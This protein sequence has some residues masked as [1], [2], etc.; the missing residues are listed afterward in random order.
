HLSVVGVWIYAIGTSLLAAPSVRR[1]LG[2]FTPYAVTA[3]VVTA[4][5]GLLNAL[6]ELADPADLVHTGY[7]LA[8]VAKTLAFVMMA[9][10]G[11]LHFIWRR[12]GTAEPQLRGPVRAEATAAS[13]ALALAT[14]L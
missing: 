9:S 14:P 8:L 1:A 10:F 5:T 4:G 3:A 2:T 11:L 12:R 13:I 7:G 6:L